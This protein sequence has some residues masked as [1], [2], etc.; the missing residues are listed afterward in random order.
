[1]KKISLF[2]LLIPLVILTFTTLTTA[3]TYTVTYTFQDPITKYN[4]D[5]TSDISMQ[6]TINNPV[7]G[8]PLLPMKTAKIL[9]HP[10]ESIKSIEIQKDPEMIL[11][12]KYFVEFGSQIDIRFLL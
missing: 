8:K 1:M 6:G 10:A 4:P 5:G 3:L 12:G 7:V 9:I 11:P 2:S